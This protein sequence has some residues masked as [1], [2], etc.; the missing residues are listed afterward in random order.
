MH[1]KVRQSKENKR[2]GRLTV[3]GDWFIKGAFILISISL[4]W[5]M[6]VN[7]VVPVTSQD[8]LF[9][10][11]QPPIEENFPIFSVQFNLP[12]AVEIETLQLVEDQIQVF[13]NEAQVD[14]L[15]LEENPIGVH[16]TLAINGSTFFDLNDENGISPYDRIQDALEDWVSSRDFADGDSWSLI[17][18]E[19]VR[20]RNT[21]SGEVWR[22]SLVGYEPN[23]RNVMPNLESLATAIEMSRDRVVPFGVDKSILYITTQPSADEIASVNELSLEAQLAG[24]QVNVWMV[25]DAYFLTNDQGGALINLAQNTGGTFFNYTGV[26]SLPNPEDTLY[27]IGSFYTLMYETSIRATGSYPFRMTIDTPGGVING[28]SVPFYLEVEPPNP[29]LLS[30]PETIE[31]QMKPSGETDPGNLFPDLAQ[32]GV[33]IEFPDRHPREIIASRLIIDGI[34]ILVKDQPPFDVLTWDISDLEESGEYTLQVD[35]T[36]NLGLSGRT[37]ETPVQIIVV[38]PETEIQSLIQRPWVIGVLVVIG[39]MTLLGVVWLIRQL[40]EKIQ[41]EKLG[42]EESEKRSRSEWQDL[43]GADSALRGDVK[44]QRLEFNELQGQQQE[45]IISD[46]KILIGHDPDG[47]DIVLDDPSIAGR[48][49]VMFFNQDRYWISQ[50]EE[51]SAT[52]INYKLWEGKPVPLKSG[53][54]VHIGDLGFRF[55]I[56]DPDHPPEVKVSKFKPSL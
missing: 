40:W 21:A 43:F 24:I 19:G 53:D 33:L 51:N 30:P 36:D 5:V 26:E 9:I 2:Q 11:V 31:R 1:A 38:E 48:H 54:I 49:A 14:I 8:F 32:I 7:L 25:G 35:V 17:T 23:F 4:A 41:S 28:E 39:V 15:S 22:M 55:T 6:V 3:P 44:L 18:N 13:E 29:I 34:V 10:E 37:I 45:Y 47:V 20:L 46:L 52:W 16:F 27:S 56:I 42:K 50:L 12:T